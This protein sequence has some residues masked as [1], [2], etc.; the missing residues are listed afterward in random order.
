M[1]CPPF[2]E[3]EARMSAFLRAREWPDRIRW[4]Q[5]S[6]V[7]IVDQ[8][9]LVHP[10]PTAS[11]MVVKNYEAAVSRGLG[12]ELRAIASGPAC[13]FCTTWAPAD[14]REAEEALQ[15]NDLKVTVPAS[16]RSARVVKNRIHWWWISRRGRPWPN[17]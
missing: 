17:I 5:A 3:A 14:A 9:F 6:D 12:V 7:T 2:S 11:L 10:S 13:T 8:V 16:P 15:P 4:L 1:G